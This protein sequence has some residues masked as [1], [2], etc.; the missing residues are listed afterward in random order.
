MKKERKKED[1][2][3]YL[4]PVPTDLGTPRPIVTDPLGAYTGR[5]WDRF[6]TPVQDADDL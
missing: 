4:P 2:M 5:P 1:P 3:V 6:D